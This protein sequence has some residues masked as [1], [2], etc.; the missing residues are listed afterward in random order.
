M[1][2]LIIDHYDSYTFNLYQLMAVI[3]QKL[4]DVI[5]HDQISPGEFMMLMADRTWD[6]II[7]SPGPGRP[8]K[9]E[10]FRVSRWVLENPQIPILGVCLGH[11]GLGYFHG[12]RVIHAPEVYHGRLSKIYH[13][14]SP[15]WAGVPSPF[16]AVRYH[17]LLVDAVLP[18]MLEKIAWTAEGLIMGLAHRFLPLWGVQFHPESIGTE[19]GERI[20]RNFRDL[21]QEWWRSQ[22]Q[23]MNQSVDQ[24]LDE[25]LDQSLDQLFPRSQNIP[26]TQSQFLTQ[27]QG[28]PQSQVLPQS[29]S[30]LLPQSQEL[31]Q[32]QPQELSQSQELSQLQSQILS[33][34]Q[35]Q[36]LP[37]PQPQVLPQPQ[38]Q[39]LSQSQELAQSQS[40]ELSQSQSQLLPQSQPQ[41]LSQPQTLPQTSSEK[42]PQPQPQNLLQV[43]AQ[44][45]LPAKAQAL[46]QTKFQQSSNS[47]NPKLTFPTSTPEPFAIFNQGVNREKQSSFLQE[48]WTTLALQFQKLPD[49]PEDEALFCHCFGESASAFWLDS[50]R[51]EPGLSRFSFMGDGSGPYSFRVQYRSQNRTLILDQS[52]PHSPPPHPPKLN[53]NLL[54]YLKAWLPYPGSPTIS[55]AQSLPFQFWGGFVGYFGYEFKQD[56]GFETPYPSPW[57]DVWLLFAD[58]FIV[59][60]HQEKSLYLVCLAPPG[61]HTQTNLWFAQMQA[62]IA[63]LPPAPP[64]ALP[65]HP[66]PLVFHWQRSPTTYR[67]DL[68]LCLKEIHEGET[69]QVCLTNQLH[70]QA[71]P[72]PLTVY[73]LLRHINPAPYAAFLRFDQL[74]IACSSPERFL[75]LSPQGTVETKPIKGTMPRGK[76]PAEDAQWIEKLRT[77]PKDQS[78]NLMIVDLLRNDLG[79]VCQVGSVKVTQL[80]AIETYAT[81]HQLVSTIQ[82]QLAPGIHGVDCLAAAFPGGSM[83]GAPK[84]R[85]LAILDRL[86]QHPRGIYSGAIGFLSYQGAMDLNIV[87]RTLVLTP[88]GT[89]LGVGGGIVALSD[90]EGEYQEML[91]KGQALMRALILALGGDA[92]QSPQILE[93]KSRDIG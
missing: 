22:D 57:P 39:K 16:E 50:S 82:G 65:P 55:Q 89:S 81:V 4:P 75:H 79:R 69:Y 77:S 67:Q 46:S 44:N 13:G 15:L 19:Y 26:I 10:D 2:T 37:Q 91:L 68:D 48:P 64:L 61:D 24:S 1:R 70:T 40:Q 72:D 23:S 54:D 8:E 90:P 32:S 93:M 62:T 58:R 52:P 36:I 87:I 30:Q 88:E 38:P 78:E 25:S 80:M 60:D 51:I 9:E 47:L 86:E 20:L 43:Q 59:F 53:I 73:R 6:N 29:Q 31:S 49:Y 84:R 35:P 74:A 76:T 21:S 5:P 18:P 45:L 28:F 12:G 11:Q 66:Q 92:H 27:S 56:C 41:K 3:N 42:L 71:T 85:T 17:S 7:L 63:T 14:G 83:T 33:Q 34:S